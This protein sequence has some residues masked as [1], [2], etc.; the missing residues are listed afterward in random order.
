MVP[1]WEYAL[2]PVIGMAIGWST[3]WLA[4]QMLFRP[5]RPV[6]LPGLRFQGLV[7]KRRAEIAERMG[8][9]IA[10]ELIH[11]DDVSRIIE[12]ADLGTPILEIID[13]RI[14]RFLDEQK[15]RLPRLAQRFVSANLLDRLRATAMDEIGRALPQLVGSIS[16]AILDKVD[17]KRIVVDKMNA[18]EVEQI[19]SIV[20]RLARRELRAI[21]LAGAVLGLLI[22][23]VQSLC[24]WLVW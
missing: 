6:R 1:G 13:E 21:E 7:P 12:S 3:N 24:F 14:G 11:A 18:V 23:A 8:A 17:F 2:G 4:V 9:I 19:E 15:R 5:R 10:E 22:G 16:A 20:H